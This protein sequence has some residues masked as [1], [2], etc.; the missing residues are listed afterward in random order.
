MSARRRIGSLACGLALAALAWIGQADPAFAAASLPEIAAELKSRLAEKS[1]QIDAHLLKSGSIRRFYAERDFRPLWVG[2]MD[3]ERQA[4]QLVEV[5]RQ[6]GREGLEPTDYAPGSIASRIGRDSSTE[7]AELDLLLTHEILR[8]VEDLRNGRTAPR[9]A[10]PELFVN[11]RKLDRRAILEGAAG[12]FDLRKFLAGFIPGNPVYGRLRKLLAEYRSIAARG[13]WPVVPKGR[14]LEEGMRHRRVE[15]LRRRLALSGDLPGAATGSTTFDFELTQAVQSFQ[16]RHGLEADGVV[17]PVT[18]RALNVSLDDRMQQVIINMERWRWMPDDLGK[19]YILVNI[20]AFGL[21]VVEDGWPL[22]DMRVVIGRPYRRTPW[23]SGRMTYLE[24]NPV[25]NVPTSIAERDYLPR[26]RK[27]PSILAEE[28]IRVL[29]SGQS[30]LQEVD[31]AKIDWHRVRAGRF[32]YVL[33]QDPGPENALGRVKFMFPNAFNV[34]LH[35]TPKGELFSR[36]VRTFSSGCIRV[37]RPLELANFLFKDDP[38]WTPER[39]DEVLREGATTRADLPAPLPVH[40]T[41]STVWAGSD[42]VVNFRADIYG[43]DALLGKAL[44]GRAYR[45]ADLGARA[46]LAAIAQ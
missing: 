37:D 16:R 2:R 27:D 11:P 45:S 4:E 31:P 33:R 18:R 35:D 12:V 30:R 44:F 5:L 42:G 1:I 40:L 29:A 14:D 8:Y 20:A 10:D 7:M 19:R 21:Q 25:W 9:A 46:V 13:G 38:T 41:Y 26:L 23:F 34:Y 32:P 17:G 6:A 28:N 24:F 22:L 43:R 3:G 39:I 15:L 36:R